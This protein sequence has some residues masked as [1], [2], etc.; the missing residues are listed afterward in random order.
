MTEVKDL[1]G[2]VGIN[3]EMVEC[4]FHFAG[5]EALQSLRCIE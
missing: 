4:I 3:R 5:T 1:F 2:A